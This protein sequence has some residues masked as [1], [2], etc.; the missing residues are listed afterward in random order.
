M[1]VTI[2]Q[3]LE[4]NLFRGLVDFPFN[5][6]NQQTVAIGEV[7]SPTEHLPVKSPQHTV[8]KERD[9]DTLQQLAQIFVPAV[10]PQGAV[11]FNVQ[12]G[13]IISDAS[14][15]WSILST[16]SVKSL[17]PQGIS[18]P[19]RASVLRPPKLDAGR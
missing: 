13:R 7:R 19:G 10:A 4:H 15:E 8:R 5:I 12:G 2:A 14:R 9:G 17:S 3:M 11:E 16:S 1:V 6:L 18:W